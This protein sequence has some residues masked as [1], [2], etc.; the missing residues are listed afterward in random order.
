MST[1]KFT[2]LG[3]E[4]V[5][6]LCDKGKREEL[7]VND[8]IITDTWG[9]VGAWGEDYQMAICGLSGAAKASAEARYLRRRAESLLISQLFSLRE[10][11]K[12]LSNV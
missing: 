2:A 9:D 1:I 10:Q 8:E 12:E 5:Y 11:V 7:R 4:V 3:A 6:E